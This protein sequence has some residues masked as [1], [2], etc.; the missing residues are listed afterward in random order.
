MGANLGGS[1]A[2]R[3]S[4]IQNVQK[5]SSN[6]TFVPTKAVIEDWEKILNEDC[7]LVVRVPGYRSRDPGLD[8]WRYQIF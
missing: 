4:S 8:S 7:G 5:G 6:E 2:G 1:S 3:R